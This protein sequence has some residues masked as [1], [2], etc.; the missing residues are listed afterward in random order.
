MIFKTFFE[1]LMA[2]AFAGLG[3]FVGRRPR[4]VIVASLMTCLVL[5]GG[6][7]R[8]EEVNSVRTEYSPMNSPS[9]QEY[10]VAKSFLNQVKGARA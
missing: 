4:A 8:F 2:E 5:S 6:F 9:R 10:A 1:H 3:R 7:V